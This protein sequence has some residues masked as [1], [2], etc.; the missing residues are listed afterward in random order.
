MQDS[1]PTEEAKITDALFEDAMHQRWEA[2]ML[3]Y[4]PNPAD[5]WVGDPPLME[6]YEELVDCANYVREAAAQDHISNTTAFM[7]ETQIR[8]IAQT[9]KMIIHNVEEG[10]IASEIEVS[11][12]AD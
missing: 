11:D 7:L 6:A 12:A 10:N 5:P 3:H 1:T 9:V 2:G 4:R 8:E